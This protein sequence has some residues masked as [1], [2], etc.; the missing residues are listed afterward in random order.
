MLKQQD[1]IIKVYHVKHTLF[2]DQ[3]CKFRKTS[4]R[5]NKYQMYLHKIDSNTAWVKPMPSKTE[6]AMITAPARCE[7][8]AGGRA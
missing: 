2:T 8:H 1:F 3:T 5:G 7:V 4:S 6:Q